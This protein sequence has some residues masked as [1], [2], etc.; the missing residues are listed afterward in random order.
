MRAITRVYDDLGRLTKVTSHG[1]ATLDPTN[2]TDIEN[3]V[4]RTYNGFGQVLSATQL[5]EPGSSKT[6]SYEYSETKSGMEFTEGHRSKRIVYPNGRKIDYWYGASG[7]ISDELSRV[8]A[9][10]PDGTP[11][12]TTAYATY[13]YVGARQPVIVGYEVGNYGHAT[14]PLAAKAKLDYF[15]GTSDTY[16]GFD[17]FGRVKT[18]LWTDGSSDLDKFAYEYDRAGNRTKRAVAIDNNSPTGYDHDGFSQTFEYDDLHRLTKVN[19]G[20]GAGS[21]EYTYTLDQT[22]NWD[23]YIKRGDPMS[24]HS[25]PNTNTQ[26]RERTPDPDHLGKSRLRR[27]RKRDD[28]PTADRFR[29]RLHGDLRRVESNR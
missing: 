16:A 14:T 17:L 11:T 24:T 1:N 15:G 4:Q 12:S 6:I 22:G 19:R 8:A 3:Q 28:D 2:E 18:Q 5:H 7:S 25:Q 26:R 21:P 20:A 27:S 23:T 13:K 10:A 9:I 29:V